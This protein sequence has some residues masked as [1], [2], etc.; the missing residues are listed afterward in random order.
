MPERPTRRPPILC[1]G[2][3]FDGSWVYE[4]FLRTAA[5]A[6][7]PAYAMNLRGYYESAWRDI[8]SLSVRD[9]LD[10]IRA[11]RRELG[12]ADAVLV[13]YSIGGLYAQIAAARD[14][15]RA[16]VLYDSSPSREAAQALGIRPSRDFVDARGHVPAIL[17][18]LPDQAIVEEMWGRR[19]TQAEYRRQLALFKRTWLSGRAFRELEI[20]RPIVG[21]ARCPTLILGIAARNRAH[22]WLYRSTPSSWYTFEGYSHGSLLV[23]PEA[24]WIADAVVRWLRL[25]YPRGRREVYRL[26]PT[27]AVPRAVVLEAQGLRMRLRYWSGW[28]RPEVRVRGPHQQFTVAMTAAGSGRTPGERVFEATFD[29]DARAGFLVAQGDEEDRPGRNELYRPELRS[30]CLLDGH[31]HEAPP[32]GRPRPPEY[33]DLKVHSRALDHDFDVKVR[34][35]AN[36]DASRTYPVAVLNDG[37]NQWKGQGMFG[38][39][40]TDA[41]AEDLMRRGRLRDVIL[42][43]VACHKYRNRAYLPPPTAKADLYADFLAEDVLPMVRRKWSVIPRPE[44]H[45]IIGSSYGAVNAVYLALK[46][47][48]CFGLVGSL[49]YA[50]VKGN[51]QIK[52]IE[53]M[54]HKPFHRIYIDCG[55]RWS[56]DQPKRDDYTGITRKLISACSRKGMVHGRDLMGVICEGHHHNEWFWRQRIGPC[57]RFLFRED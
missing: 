41:I 24:D 25:D 56:H 11:V 14:G 18:F 39:W 17:Q 16:V 54:A 37:Q 38:G 53:A 6:G 57:L 28:E 40:H 4:R 23:S 45:A 20:D 44:S 13:G 19:V 33:I 10:D 12:L 27:G 43:A 30:P 22:A 42:V 47:P 2:G 49:S 35:P 26:G 5:R 9:Y 48:D 1:I 34:L 36:Y 8:G 31:F 32:P 3:A 29:L 7:F 15:A 46:R 55:T 51:P 21:E 52:A 50:Y